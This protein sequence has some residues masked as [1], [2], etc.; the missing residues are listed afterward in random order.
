MQ[1]LPCVTFVMQVDLN[2]AEA[3]P[4]QLTQSIKVVRIILFQR[5]KEGMARRSRIAVPKLA[6]EARVFTQP[7][8]NPL[9]G[10]LI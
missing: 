7:V 5:K 6:K 3:L 2:L 8:T 4:A 10:N 1:F 9:V